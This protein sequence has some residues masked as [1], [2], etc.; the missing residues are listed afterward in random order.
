MFN[1]ALDILYAGTGIGLNTDDKPNEPIE[2]DLSMSLE[3]F[4]PP[5]SS[6]LHVNHEFPLPLS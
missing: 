1:A 4:N 5:C 2:V 3:L 6:G